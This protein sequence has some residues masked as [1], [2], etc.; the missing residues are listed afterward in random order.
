M[1]EQ[2]E[3]I[4]ANAAEDIEKSS[5]INDLEEVKNKY[6]SRKGEFNEIRENI[7]R[8]LQNGAIPPETFQEKLQYNPQKLQTV[9]HF[10]ILEEELETKD[11]MVMLKR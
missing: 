9:L 11:G 7:E 3:K 8:M 1:K 5:S 4:Y 6:L 2:L 10:L